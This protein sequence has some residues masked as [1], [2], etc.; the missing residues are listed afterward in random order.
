MG[1]PQLSPDQVDRKSIKR[2]LVVRQHDQ[3]GDFLLSTPVFRALREHFPTAYIAIVT[4]SYTV[5]AARNNPY[6]NAAIPFYETGY[7]W[8][9]KSII[10][11]IKKI[12]SGYDL[13][14]VL[15]TVSHSLSADLIA[16]FSRPR[17]VLG[18][19]Y[20]RFPGTRRNFFYHLEAPYIS[21]QR[22]QTEQN[23]DIVRY[24]GVDTDD[25]TECMHLTNKELISVQNFL[26]NQ[27][28]DT[29]AGIV[30]LHPGAG[31]IEN[32]W[33]AA[34][35]AQVANYLCDQFGFRVIVSWG[36][37]EVE[38]GEKAIQFLSTSPVALPA[39]GLRKLAAFIAV[40]NI[41]LCNDTGVMHVAAAVGTP[42]VAVFGPTDPEIWKPIGEK[43]IAIR[44]KGNTCLSVS[45][46][47]V[48]AAAERLVNIKAG[49]ENRFE[50]I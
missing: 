4:R 33:P 19:A 31:K 48:Q 49:F 26:K 13:T 17:I 25:R 14:V 20:Y 38:L 41:F 8:T 27:G 5:D 10:Q 23:L 22:H 12:R 36:H 50:V 11:F 43:Y 28:V 39:I 42:L 32:R 37:N 24:I 30:F 16:Y 46:K 1:L 44:G 34:N 45:V 21:A 7:N 35:F 3:L 18:S 47:E 15:N 29:K 2:I 40:S 9:L 6:F